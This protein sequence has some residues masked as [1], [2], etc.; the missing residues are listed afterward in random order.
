MRIHQTLS[1][2]ESCSD[3]FNTEPFI[4]L[5]LLIDH[6]REKYHFHIIHMSLEERNTV[7][8]DILEYALTQVPDAVKEYYLIKSDPTCILKWIP[9]AIELLYTVDDPNAD[10]IDSDKRIFDAK[11]IVN[12]GELLVCSMILQFIIRYVCCQLLKVTIPE[13]IIINKNFID[14]AYRKHYLYY[15]NHFSLKNLIASHIQLLEEVHWDIKL[16]PTKLICFTTT[17][18]FLHKLPDIFPTEH[19]SSVNMNETIIN[20]IRSCIFE[21]AERVCLFSLRYFPSQEHFVSELKNFLD[22]DKLTVMVLIINVQLV[23]TR[24]INF[25]R[26]MI[27]Q[28]EMLSKKSRKFFALVLHY[29]PGIFH[30]QGF[31]SSNSDE[32]QNTS[33]YPSHFVLGWD[34]YYIDSIS[35]PG[36]IVNIQTWLKLTIDN[37]EVDIDWKHDFVKQLKESLIESILFDITSFVSFRAKKIDSRLTINSETSTITR[38]MKY[39]RKIFECTDIDFI[40]CEKF[41]HYWTPKAIQERLVIASSAVISRDS[42]LNIS[43]YVQT[44]IRYLF[45][46][47]V[48]EMLYRI[49]DDLNLDTLFQQETN[50]VAEATDEENSYAVDTPVQSYPGAEDDNDFILPDINKQ[51]CDLFERILVDYSNLPSLEDLQLVNRNNDMAVTTPCWSREFPF[52]KYISE[53]MEDMIEMSLSEIAPSALGTPHGVVSEKKQEVD[54]PLQD[55]VKN[56]FI[57]KMKKIQ[58]TGMY[59]DVKYPIINIALGAFEDNENWKRYKADFIISRLELHVDMAKFIAE[60]ARLWGNK[61]NQE[62]QSVIERV[63]SFHVE[64]YFNPPDS[65]RQLYLVLNL[66]K[67]IDVDLIISIQSAHDDFSAYILNTFHKLLAN[68]GDDISKWKEWTLNYECLSSQKN[69]NV[70]HLTPICKALYLKLHFLYLNNCCDRVNWSF[71]PNAI[72]LFGEY[73]YLPLNEG[74]DLLSFMSHLQRFMGETTDRAVIHEFLSR[75]LD[76]YIDVCSPLSDSDCNYLFKFILDVFGPSTGNFY[77]ILSF[78]HLEHLLVQLLHSQPLEKNE[79]EQSI[80]PFSIFLKEIIGYSIL[81][82][83]L[84]RE[85]SITMSLAPCFASYFPPNKNLE[86]AP[87]QPTQSLDAFIPPYYYNPKNYFIEQAH[88]NVAVHM[89]SDMAHLYFSVSMDEIERVMHGRGFEHMMRQYSEFA[90]EGDSRDLEVMAQIE[91]QAL[92]Q[93][94]LKKYASLFE[95]NPLMNPAGLDQYQQNFP[96]V[97]KSFSRELLHPDCGGGKKGGHSWVLLSWIYISYSSSESCTTYLRGLIDRPI[98]SWLKDFDTKMVS[99]LDQGS[100]FPWTANPYAAISKILKEIQSK[101]TIVST[102]ISENPSINKLNDLRNLLAREYTPSRCQVIMTLWYAV[103]VNF[104]LVKKTI[105]LDEEIT[106]LFPDLSQSKQKFIRYFANPGTKL[107]HQSSAFIRSLLTQQSCLQKS[108]LYFIEYILTS[109]DSTCFYNVLIFDPIS[110]IYLPGSLTLKKLG[111]DPT[112]RIDLICCLNEEGLYSS[113]SFLLNACNKRNS[114]S[115]QS[116]YLINM[117]NYV[118]LLLSYLTQD[119]LRDPDVQKKLFSQKY[120][121]NLVPNLIGDINKCWKLLVEVSGVYEEDMVSVIKHFFTNNL[122]GGGETV[123]EPVHLVDTKEVVKFELDIY[124]RF[125]K[126]SLTLNKYDSRRNPDLA[127]NL[128]TLNARIPK[129]ITAKSI[130]TYIEPKNTDQPNNHD[131]LLAFISLR[132]PLRVGAMLLPVALKLYEIFHVNLNY[133]LLRDMAISKSLSNFVKEVINRQQ[134][135]A[136]LRELAKNFEI[137]LKIYVELRKPNLDIRDLSANIT[138][139]D[140]LNVGEKGRGTDNPPLNLLLTVIKD[141]VSLH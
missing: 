94:I 71:V 112:S 7:A 67:N 66:Q 80:L 137:Y 126:L 8:I 120:S 60:F 119:I 19:A 140:V 18:S 93:V 97:I 43:D 31:N 2:Q 128:W 62:G 61:F 16:R 136:E 114:F 25:V 78:Q 47:Y 14:P 53:M 77:H 132:K 39:L 139:F 22:S 133:V 10:F 48:I 88:K 72:A 24:K 55:R 115:L 104:Y 26:H 108:I 63:T 4:Y 51:N 121:A 23:T 117:L 103:F 127:H 89:R 12:H 75:F 110:V 124:Y 106:R 59:L 79:N 46:Q 90:V 27:E 1:K 49:N 130:L 73:R 38:R 45:S 118:S 41:V 105:P 54:I 5:D 13:T 116:L 56:M 65:S 28:E 69:I 57:F 6:L 32:N 36:N 44:N 123:S 111:E 34:H 107:P 87:S 50:P 76:H 21:R 37:D 86:P 40:L 131:V 102:K 92:F 70:E 20:D 122:S 134:S 100:D 85:D 74:S 68:C 11:L 15:Q 135:L 33:R 82:S 91:K 101:S 17:S 42:N 96:D 58:S 64:N 30:S 35:A 81:E 109:P 98:H 84:K 125:H 95:F 52:S 29:S 141:I 138:M 129:P 9:H 113:D 99:Y 83:P 3:A